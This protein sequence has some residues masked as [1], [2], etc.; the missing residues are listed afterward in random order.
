MKEVAEYELNYGAAH[1][2]MWMTTE[3]AC[4]EADHPSMGW[5]AASMESGETA[6]LSQH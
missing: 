4:A 2:D 5:Q 3:R 1:F 6:D